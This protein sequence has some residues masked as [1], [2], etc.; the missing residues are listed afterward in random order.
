MPCARL[1]PYGSPSI[2]FHERLFVVDPAA[3][4]LGGDVRSAFRSLDAA[5]IRR[6]M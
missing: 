4:G 5:F 6:R 3:F 2:A 1:E